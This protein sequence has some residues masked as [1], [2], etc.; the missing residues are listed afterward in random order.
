MAINRESASTRPPRRSRLLRV[1]MQCLQ[2]VSEHVLGVSDEVEA[3][4]E[5]FI[6]K[7]KATDYLR[8]GA[9]NLW[10]FAPTE[11]AAYKEAFKEVLSESFAFNPQQAGGWGRKQNINAQER[12]VHSRHAT[13]LLSVS[14]NTENT[15]IALLLI[16]ASLAIV[17]HKE[18]HE[19]LE[20]LCRV[21][22]ETHQILLRASFL[23]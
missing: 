21:G 2:L 16:R 9:D 23:W 22:P 20:L 8:V 19:M 10:R 4:V 5:A 11:I 18:T 12:N 6:K 1:A 17:G 7:R 3:F 14:V 15:Y 13:S